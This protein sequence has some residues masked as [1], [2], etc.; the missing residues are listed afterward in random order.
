MRLGFSSPATARI[1]KARREAALLSLLVE[2]TQDMISVIEV[3][4]TIRYVSPSVERMLGY[5]AEEMIGTKVVDY[6]PPDDREQHLSRFADVSDTGAFDPRA[7]KLG[8]PQGRLLALC[9]RNSHRHVGRPLGEWHGCR[10]SGCYRA[11][12]GGGE[13]RRLNETLEARVYERTA[14]WRPWSPSWR[15]RSRS[16]RERGAVPHGIRAAGRRHG[17]HLDRR[18]VIR[19][20]EKF[21]QITGYAREELLERN[22]KD[23]THP[24]DLDGDL[25]HFNRMLSGES[26]VTP[27]RSATQE[28]LFAGLGQACGVAGARRGG[29]PDYF[30]SVTEDITAASRP[31]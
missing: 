20:N 10:C 15:R 28:R 2:N 7:G 21:C 23:I 29:K 1:V 3:D 16:A 11:Q 14:N 31:S 8:A 27:P 26:T 19:V 30:V 5:R 12:A 9:R 13:I 4:S 24:G 6:A 25:D 17:P 22:F 18:T